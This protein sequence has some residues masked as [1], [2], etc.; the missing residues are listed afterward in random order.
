MV[1]TPPPETGIGE[2]E[3][4]KI[5]DAAMRGLATSNAD[6]RRLIATHRALVAE[7]D[8]AE[9]RR[10][11]Y[12]QLAVAYKR[13]LQSME[14]YKNEMMAERDALVAERD[15][16]RI[17]RDGMEGER[18]AEREISIGWQ[19]KHDEMEIEVTA[20]RARLEGVEKERDRLREEVV[21]THVDM[22]MTGAN[23]EQWSECLACGET[24]AAGDEPNHTHDCPLFESLAF[25]AAPDSDG[26]G[27][28]GNG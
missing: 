18:D 15:M 7:R 12:E 22:E 14:D 16:W 8:R 21:R 5:A 17:A 25:L 24:G 13:D 2:A 3:I 10:A 19:T 23:N 28:D 6:V 20:L 1:T 4:R 27:G 26:K 9:E 11:A